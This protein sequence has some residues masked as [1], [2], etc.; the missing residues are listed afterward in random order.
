MAIAGLT[1]RDG[2]GLTLFV[3]HGRQEAAAA[4]YIGAFGATSPRHWINPQDRRGRRHRHHDRPGHLHRQRRQPASAR[5]TRTCP[6]PARSRRPAAAAPIFQIC[7][8][9]LDATLGARDRGGRHRPHAGA[10]RRLG[11][12]RRHHRRSVRPHLGAGGDPATGC[13]CRTTTRAA[14]SSSSKR[15]DRIGRWPAQTSP[16]S[17][18][19]AA[20]P[21]AAGR[22]SAT[23]CGEWNTLVEE[24]AAAPAPGGPAARRARAACSRSSR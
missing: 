3:P 7:V 17:A 9:D 18:R 24:G 19:T 13:R 11:R 14:T 2:L 8:D 16:S 20:R 15:P 10:G 23:A 5:P 4:F 22:A 1:A 6:G 12:P 21:A